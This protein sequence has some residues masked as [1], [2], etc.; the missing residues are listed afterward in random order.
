[1]KRKGPA[2]AKEKLGFAI[3]ERRHGLGIS[4]EELAGRAALHRTY[5]ADV[6]RGS[7]NV[8]LVNI[9][10]LATALGCMVAELMKEAEL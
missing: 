9:K 10:K 3:R 8:S 7:R 6:E 1:M 5:V 4:Q 2:D